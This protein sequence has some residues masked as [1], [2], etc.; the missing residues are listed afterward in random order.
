MLGPH[1]EGISFG[2]V[3]S[4]RR[5]NPAGSQIDMYL[6]AFDGKAFLIWCRLFHAPFLFSGTIVDLKI[7]P[8][9]KPAMF[10]YTPAGP[11]ADRIAD[12]QGNDQPFTFFGPAA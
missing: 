12:R 4:L 6:V 11:V 7:Q 1:V 10:G 3:N 8:V 9:R 2:V 5:L